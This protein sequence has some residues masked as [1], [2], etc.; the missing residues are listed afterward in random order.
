[1]KTTIDKAGRL[2]VPKRVREE[3]GDRA[4]MAA[5]HHAL[6]VYHW[7]NAERD[8][9]DEHAAAAVDAFADGQPD[10]GERSVLGHAF[11]MQAFLS[12]HA[13]DLDA[14]HAHIGRAQSAAAG[15]DEP[16]V[17]VRVQLIDGLLG[18]AEGDP[19]SR[20]RVVEVL[21]RASED[22]ARRQDIAPLE[23]RR[24]VDRI[25]FRAAVYL[26]PAD[27]TLPMARAALQQSARDLFGPRSAAAA[28]L[29]AA[30]GEPRTPN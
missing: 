1:M 4:G 19:A 10:D 15:T 16:T 13:S 11:A 3:A 24:T 26:L 18:V 12:L 9:A 29:A 28:A 25:F 27:A 7:Y 30:A 21:D 8:K 6:A 2:V 17:G 22:L 23:A 14:A 20:R 5:N